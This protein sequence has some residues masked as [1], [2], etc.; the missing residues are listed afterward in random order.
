VRSSL[1]AG[2][3]TWNPSASLCT[4]QPGR[5]A[6]MAT[7]SAQRMPRNLHVHRLCTFVRARPVGGVHDESEIVA[8]TRHT[9]HARCSCVPRAT[10]GAPGLSSAIFCRGTVLS[11]L[12]TSER[13]R[14]VDVA[15][16]WFAKRE[17]PSF[18]RCFI[19]RCG[20]R[21]QKVPTPGRGDASTAATRTKTVQKLVRNCS[22]G[23]PT[24]FM[25]SSTPC[26][27]RVHDGSQA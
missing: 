19:G 8:Y 6:I 9:R 11:R 18:Y 25:A 13:R 23:M 16:R 21:L 14:S 24:A 2:K 7:I 10:L 3:R 4:P 15:I 1:A 17:R 12:A 22:L 27:L 26:S 20:N 5:N